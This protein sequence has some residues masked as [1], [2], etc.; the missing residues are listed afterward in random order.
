MK[1]FWIAVLISLFFGWSSGRDDPKNKEM[2][3]WRDF[4]VVE[5]VS[6]VSGDRLEGF[7]SIRAGEAGY[8]LRFLLRLTL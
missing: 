6:P 2:D 5:K 1:F 8:Y 3:P 4:S 7:K